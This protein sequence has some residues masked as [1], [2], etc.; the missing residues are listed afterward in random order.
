LLK[1]NNLNFQ[2][3]PE[4]IFTD[5]F[6]SNKAEKMNKKELSNFDI[7]HILK[8][9]QNNI[10]LLAEEFYV[11]STAGM[12]PYNMGGGTNNHYDDIIIV[13]FNP[14]GKL[15]WGSNILKSDFKPSY[16]AFLK[17]DELHVILN[18]GSD[19]NQLD[20]GRTKIRKGFFESSALYDFSYTIDGNESIQ[21]IQDNKGKA[22]YLP[23]FGYYSSGK[24]IMLSDSENAR[25]FMSL[26]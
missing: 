4:K 19:L 10:F 5:M 21:K 22:Y 9:S 16:N 14:N 23:N 25:K 15:D 8:D 12:G 7:N 6:G 17:N 13:K 11:T 1:I 3:L 2:D 24:F 20:D 26:E 18:T